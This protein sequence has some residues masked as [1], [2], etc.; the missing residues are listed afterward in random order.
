MTKKVNNASQSG[1]IKKATK[2]FSEVKADET[3]KADDVDFGT[4]EPVLGTA[5]IDPVA[6]EI[7]NVEI[8]DLRGKFSR[9]KVK[10]LPVLKIAGRDIELVEINKSGS[11][12]PV[13]FM[14]SNYYGDNILAQ[15]HAGVTPNYSNEVLPLSDLKVYKAVVNDVEIFMTQGSVLIIDKSFTGTTDYEEWLFE[16]E[17]L[18][19]PKDNNKRTLI[20]V[21]SQVT[22]ET[23]N[24]DGSVTINNSVLRAKMI[25]LTNSRINASRINAEDIIDL[26]CTQL[27][28]YETNSTRRL[29]VTKSTLGSV[30]L[31]GFNAITLQSVTYSP[32]GDRFNL[33]CWGHGKEVNLRI[34]DVQ[35]TP[36]TAYFTYREAT[37]EYPSYAPEVKI[38]RRIDYGYFS[39]ISSV[40]FVRLNESDVLV[41]NK[42][43]YGKDLNPTAFSPEEAKE[44]VGTPFGMTSPYGGGFLRNT[45]LTPYSNSGF[46]MDKPWMD[47]REVVVL[48]GGYSPLGAKAPLGKTTERL[49]DV[50]LEQIKSRN[51]LY[52]ELTSL[53]K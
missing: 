36:Y 6:G 27:N 26:D 3:V 38:T 21:G 31:N 46:P 45:T 13:I 16:A 47:A 53:V 49:V 15:G 7:A 18:L 17:P 28:S 40:P 33:G 50:L 42:V 44:S 23:L 11:Q 22:A 1:S 51:N 9:P 41:N 30:T 24:V 14:T 39:G 12:L 52:I 48:S 5:I 10:D 19:G 35:L 37:G 20:V 4:A 25:Y 29:R 2:S 32:G 8:V 43:F 34:Q